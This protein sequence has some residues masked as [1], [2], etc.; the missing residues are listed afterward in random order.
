MGPV[1]ITPRGSRRASVPTP[2]ISHVPDPSPQ[3]NTPCHGTRRPDEGTSYQPRLLE[4]LRF[5]P[6]PAGAT[7]RQR[8]GLMLSLARVP[9]HLALH[10]LWEAA[11]T[12]ASERH[13]AILLL[14]ASALSFWGPWQEKGLPISH[15]LNAMFHLSR[16]SWSHYTFFSRKSFAGGDQ[17][18]YNKVLKSDFCLLHLLVVSGQKFRRLYC[19]W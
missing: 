10:L 9:R 8:S 12:P 15:L 18:S 1:P 11:N 5:P 4:T 3:T 14:P 16:P 13:S 7:S 2:I 19:S 17:L 6:E